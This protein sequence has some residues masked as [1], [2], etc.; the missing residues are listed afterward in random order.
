MAE[1]GIDIA[2]QPSKSIIDVEYIPFDYMVTVCS[3]AHEVCPVF[4]GHAKVLHIGFD[5]PPLL[6]AQDT[7]ENALKHYRRVRDEIRVFVEQLPKA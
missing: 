2:D 4:P 1:V 5:D 6:A 3:D 7:P